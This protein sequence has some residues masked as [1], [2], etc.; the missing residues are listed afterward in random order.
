MWISWI[1]ACFITLSLNIAFRV[2]THTYI[3]TERP[4]TE[5]LPVHILPLLPLCFLAPPP[6]FCFLYGTIPSLTA[7]GFLFFFVNHLHRIVPSP[8]RLHCTTMHSTRVQKQPSLLP[9]FQPTV[10][11][12]SFMHACIPLCPPALL[13]SSFIT[14]QLQHLYLSHF[15]RKETPNPTYNLIAVQT[16]S[17]EEKACVKY[18]SLVP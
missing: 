11:V 4:K 9:V 17:T 18:A 6:L 13:A 1:R 2:Y 5:D 3:Q 12:S 8:S 7:T 16:P 10:L 15:Q 14:I